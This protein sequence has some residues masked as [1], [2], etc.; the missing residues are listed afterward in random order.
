MTKPGLIMTRSIATLCWLEL[1]HFVSNNWKNR[2]QFISFTC[3]LIYSFQYHGVNPEL[4]IDWTFHNCFS[5][6]Y[7]S[8]NKT[9]HRH[10]IANKPF[11][12]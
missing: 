10:S 6:L 5:L 3:S 9:V 11:L 4:D 7:G 8:T 2:L 1:A 12:I